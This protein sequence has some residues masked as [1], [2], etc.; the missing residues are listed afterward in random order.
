MTAMRAAIFGALLLCALTAAQEAAAQQR[1]APTAGPEVRV[2]VESAHVAV[3][4]VFWIE[5]FVRH[6]EQSPASGSAS[7]GGQVSL[8]PGTPFE[9]VARLNTQSSF[10]MNTT[11]GQTR[12]TREQRLRWQVRATQAGRHQLV[13]HVDGKVVRDPNAFITVT[14][15]VP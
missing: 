4:Q 6:S 2:T 8:A 5:V 11:S 3:N 15:A 1:P 9:L 13:V 7:R 14:G 10:Q 12:I